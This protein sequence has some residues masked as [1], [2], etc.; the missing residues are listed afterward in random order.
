MFMGRTA[1][2]RIS[3]L[4][5]CFYKIIIKGKRKSVHGAMARGI[6]VLPAARLSPFKEK[7][8]QVHPGMVRQW[9]RSPTNRAAPGNDD[10]CENDHSQHPHQKSL[11]GTGQHA[12]V[13]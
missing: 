1:Y 7:E 8:D 9:R 10:H 3:N 4:S 13:S 11:C 2:L 5:Y 12:Q 6:A